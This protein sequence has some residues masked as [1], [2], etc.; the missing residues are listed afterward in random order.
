MLELKNVSKRFGER[1]ILKGIDLTV[2]NG[3][4]IGLLGKNG[5]GKTTMIKCINHLY[6]FQGNIKV[7]GICYEDNP[8]EYLRN[9]GILLE[10]SY[11][12]YMSALENLRAFAKLSGIKFHDVEKEMKNLLDIIGLSNAMEKK[13]KDF[14]ASAAF[15]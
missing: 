6:K 13:V 2:E 10:P 3:Q 9:V 5:A 8:K 12:D 14:S 11:Y 1:E 15:R 7:K 4:I